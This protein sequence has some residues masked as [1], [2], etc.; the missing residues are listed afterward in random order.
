MEA[1]QDHQAAPDMK[2]FMGKAGGLRTGKSL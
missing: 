1:L 2:A